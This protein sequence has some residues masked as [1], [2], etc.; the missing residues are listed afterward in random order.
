MKRNILKYADNGRKR[1]ARRQRFDL[2]FA[3]IC[4]IARVARKNGDRIDWP[5]HAV[6]MAFSA[7]FEA[8]TRA[9]VTGS[10]HV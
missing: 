7:G 5:Y 6:C 8:G 1:I 2:N 9:S 4:E 10:P 3:E